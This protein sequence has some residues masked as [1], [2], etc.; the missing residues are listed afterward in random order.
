MNKPQPSA[1][2]LTT[3]LTLTVIAGAM[4][5]LGGFWMWVA[6]IVAAI[7]AYQTVTGIYRLASAV[8]YI[9]DRR[10]VPVETDTPTV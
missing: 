4:A 10:T 2:T 6:L 3:G 7:G 5:L 1:V 9:A 8:D